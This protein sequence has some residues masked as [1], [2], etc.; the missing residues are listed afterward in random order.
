MSLSSSAL[1]RIHFSRR[2][3]I[4]LTIPD[5]PILPPAERTLLCASLRQFQLG[6]GS[7]GCNLLRFARTFAAR[8]GDADLPEAVAGLIAEEQRHSRWLALVLRTHGE[9]LLRRHWVDGVFRLLRRT[10]GFGLEVAVLVSAEVVA[11]PYY[12]AVARVSTLPSLR[13]ICARILEDEAFHLQF[14]AHNLSLVVRDHFGLR[15][16]L[17]RALQLVIGLVVWQQHGRLLRAGGYSL[18]SFCQECD[19]LLLEV[20][21]KSYASRLPCQFDSASAS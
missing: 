14:Q 6:E 5:D 11:V 19:A 8:I 21:R 9:P 4:E 17:H 10:V 2:W 13:A 16:A 3:P 18:A 7:D 1:W 12:S 15:H 20:Q